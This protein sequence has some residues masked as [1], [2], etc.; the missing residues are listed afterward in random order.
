MSAQHTPGPDEMRFAAE[1]LRQYDDTHDGGKQTRIA[2]KVAEWLD[3][4]ADAK[5]IRDLA[6]QHG[7]PAGKLR[8]K[9]SAIAKAEGRS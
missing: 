1:W 5:E 3:A 4:Q 6:R 9:L 8:V 7:V 2:A